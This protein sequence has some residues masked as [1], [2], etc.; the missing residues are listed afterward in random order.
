MS[1]LRFV[2]I[3]ARASS[4]EAEQARRR[5]FGQPDHTLCDLSS[6]TALFLEF[7]SQRA[8]QRVMVPIRRRQL[9]HI[10]PA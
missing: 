4:N 9:R 7:Y 10:V 1:K 6:E 8:L 5:C 2:E 3:L